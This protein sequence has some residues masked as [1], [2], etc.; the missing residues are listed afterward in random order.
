[1]HLKLFN[2]LTRGVLQKSPG[3][4]LE[5]IGVINAQLFEGLMNIHNI[6]VDNQN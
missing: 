3:S 1:M 2:V 5:L 4:E 6:Y